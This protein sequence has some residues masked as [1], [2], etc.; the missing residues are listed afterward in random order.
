MARPS[1]SSPPKIEDLATHNAESVAHTFAL[2]KKA[3][4]DPE[5]VSAVFIRACKSQGHLASLEL[6]D[7]GIHAMS[8]NTMKTHADNN[9]KILWTQLDAYRKTALKKHQQQVQS[10]TKPSRGSKINL[11]ARLAGVERDLQQKTN[12]II[13][14]VDRYDDLLVLSRDHARLNSTFES[15]L[16]RHLDRYIYMDNR[17]G[18]SKLRLIDG[19]K[20]D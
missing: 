3:I 13:Q 20:N 10:K 2:L 9:G 18:R 17:C 11:E 7:F 19:E 5:S 4:D 14:F 8:L 16:K 15:K 12:E 1:T 6:P